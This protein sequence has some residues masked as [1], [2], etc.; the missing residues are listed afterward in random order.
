METAN[1]PEIVLPLGAAAEPVPDEEGKSAVPLDGAPEADVDDPPGLPVPPEVDAGTPDDEPKLCPGTE[2]PNEGDVPDADPEPDEGTPPPVDE[3]TGK[4]VVGT[5]PELGGLVPVPLVGVTL[6]ESDGPAVLP[7]DDDEPLAGPVEVGAPVEA[8]EPDPDEPGTEDTEELVPVGEEPV[9]P[10]L[11]LLPPPPPPPPP[12]PPLLVVWEREAPEVLDDVR[13]EEVGREVGRLV[14]G[15]VIV[16]TEVVGTAVVPSVVLVLVLVPVPV[17]VVVPDEV[18]LDLEL[19]LELDVVVEETVVLL[20]LLL[21]LLEDDEEV[22][23]VE[24][25][26]VDEEEDDVVVVEVLIGVKLSPA[27]RPGT[28]GT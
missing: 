8:P 10:L 23:V 21:L 3:P 24:L 1:R 27:A 15:R 5:E 13:S 11:L 20:L 14:V 9:E 7:M 26:V 4:E 19:E 18:E 2:P 22:V 16:G 12:L 6:L 28:R 25:E 17:P